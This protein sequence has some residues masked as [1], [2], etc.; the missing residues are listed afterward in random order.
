MIG[1]LIA[2]FVALVVGLAYVAIGAKQS[3]ARRWAMVGVTVVLLTLGT[4]L[5]LEFLGRPKPID[6]EWRTGEATVEHYLFVEGQAIYVWLRWPEK[7]APSA[8]Q[9]PW[10]EETAKSLQGAAEQAEQ[11]GGEVMAELSGTETQGEEMEGE[12]SIPLESSL[13]DRQPMTFY[14]LP[15]PT[16]PPKKAPAAAQQFQVDRR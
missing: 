7:L 11:E 10:S 15:Q 16:L 6:Y 4:S 2:V 3:R 5:T 8:Y 1:G 13:E 12:A 9:L 14:A